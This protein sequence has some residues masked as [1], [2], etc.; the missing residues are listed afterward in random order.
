MLEVIISL[1]KLENK[2]LDDVIQIANI[3]RE[4]RGGFKKRIF[5]EKVNI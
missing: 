3:K 4:K 2:S 1:A 5:L